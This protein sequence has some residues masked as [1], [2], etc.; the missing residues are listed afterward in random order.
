MER[1]GQSGPAEGDGRG[2]LLDLQHEQLAA[3]SVKVV[4]PQGKNYA[5]PSDDAGVNDLGS[6]TGSPGVNH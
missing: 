4:S 6:D 3:S 5:G 2:R 1:C